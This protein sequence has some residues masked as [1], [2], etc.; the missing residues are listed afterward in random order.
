MSIGVSARHGGRVHAA[1]QIRTTRDA[2]PR[3]KFAPA[4]ANARQAPRM[5]DPR[6]RDSRTGH[7]AARSRA[8]GAA[9]RAPQASRW[10]S[11]I[12]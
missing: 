11:S 1:A 4:L 2:T 10:I 8:T 3:N 12:L 5:T 7:A 6:A 9:R